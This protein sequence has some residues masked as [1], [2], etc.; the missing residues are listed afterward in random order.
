MT[1]NNF[2][3]SDINIEKTSLLIGHACSGSLIYSYT[4]TSV[5][6]IEILKDKKLHHD[7]K[8]IQIYISLD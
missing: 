6:A 3:R 7:E 4:T 2:K 1:K 5:P 8:Y